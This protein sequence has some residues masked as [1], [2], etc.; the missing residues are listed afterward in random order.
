MFVVGEPIRI[1]MDIN[2]ITSR[3]VIPFRA[4]EIHPADVKIEKFVP[5]TRLVIVTILYPPVMPEL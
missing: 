1:A 4:K 3:R 5:K 2:E